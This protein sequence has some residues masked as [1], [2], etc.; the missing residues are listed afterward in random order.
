MVIFFFLEPSFGEFLN[1]D[2]SI[3]HFGGIKQCKSM[4]ILRD[5]PYNGTLFGLV[6]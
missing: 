5:F 4:V 3:T 6:I 1:W 2:H